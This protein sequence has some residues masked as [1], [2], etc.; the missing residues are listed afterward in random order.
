MFGFLIYGLFTPTHYKP[1]LKSL[2]QI[3]SWMKSEFE[4]LFLKGTSGFVPFRWMY[5]NT[6][7]VDDALIP[8]LPP[9][10]H[11]GRIIYLFI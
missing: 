11:G 1:K 7:I 8:L 5:N 6:P 2:F 4:N 9:F 3:G 10:L